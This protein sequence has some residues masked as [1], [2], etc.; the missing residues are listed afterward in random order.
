MPVYAIEAEGDATERY[1]V[2][3][4]SEAEAREK[5]ER[6]EVE[7]A[8]STEVSGSEIVKIEKEED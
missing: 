2:E 7:P 1:S 4:A 8:W 6:G 5:F 3:A